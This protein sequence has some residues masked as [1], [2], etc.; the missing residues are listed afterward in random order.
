MLTEE[1]EVVHQA[2]RKNGLLQTTCTIKER[3]CRGFR[4]ANLDKR[5]T[6]YALHCETP[7]QSIR[8]SVP[9]RKSEFCQ[10]VE[11]RRRRT[12]IVGEYDYP[13]HSKIE[14]LSRLETLPVVRLR[15]R[16]DCKRMRILSGP[17][18][19][20]KRAYI[21]LQSRSGR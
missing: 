16:N 15:N 9:F 5:R 20:E 3:I 7:F 1:K 4:L 2:T 12:C 17:L 13:K 18:G 11:S 10:A 19:L 14:F 8:K 21:W 6:G